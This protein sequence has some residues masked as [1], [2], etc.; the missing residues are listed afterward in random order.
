MTFVRVLCLAV[1][2][3]V[4]SAAAGPTVPL[5]ALQ[6]ATSATAAVSSRISVTMPQDDAA[7]I[8]NGQAV[9]GR[10]TYRNIESARLSPGTQAK[11]T[12]TA[13]WKP[14][15]YTEMTRTKQVQ[16]TAGEP[17]TVDLSIEA[18]DDRVKVIYVPTPQDVSEEMVRL[19][20]VGATDVVAT[21]RGAVT[22]GSPLLPSVA[23][24][25]VASAST[26]MRNG[27][28]NRRPT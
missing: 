6:S 21:N 26:S 2:I 14:N 22:P 10:G 11:T 3:P 15:G 12:I 9:E 18:A 28:K 5:L 23:A 7:L 19:V 16:F 27:P 20:G 8:V 25:S 4:A 17:V 13:Q 24:R 1:V